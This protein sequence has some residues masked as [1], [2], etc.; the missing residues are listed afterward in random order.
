MAHMPITFSAQDVNLALFLHTDAM[1]VT[2]HI[3]RWDATKIL[4]DNGREAKLIF[5]TTFKKWVSAENS[6]RN[7]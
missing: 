4:I 6:L 3:D 7:Q 1:V 2:V 5:L